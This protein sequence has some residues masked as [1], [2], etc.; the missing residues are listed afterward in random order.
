MEEKLWKNEDLKKLEEALPR[1]KNVIWKK[2]LDCTKQKQEWD[3]T[4][5]TVKFLWT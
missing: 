1:L 4:H 5:Y 2:H 3:V